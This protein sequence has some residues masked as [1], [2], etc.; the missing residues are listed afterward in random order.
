MHIEISTGGNVEAPEALASQIRNMVEKALDRFSVRITRVE[1]HVSDAN[2]HKN[3]HNDKHCM[4][5][6]RLEGRQPST[7]T[8]QAATL[9]QPWSKLLAARPVR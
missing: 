9:E 1:V 5:E 7:V 4:I 3:G 6:T 2:S 8:H